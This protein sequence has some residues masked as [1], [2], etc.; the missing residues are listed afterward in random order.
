MFTYKMLVGTKPA[1]R[2]G[3][4]PL[5]KKQKKFNHKKLFLP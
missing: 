4:G 5:A 2:M 3:R 1:L